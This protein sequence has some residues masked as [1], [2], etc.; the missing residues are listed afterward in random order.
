MKNIIVIFTKQLKDTLKNKAVL[1]QFIL[2]PVMA[3]IMENSI[4]MDAMPMPEHFFVTMFSSMFVGMAPLVSIASIIA[5]EKEQN[6]L[7]ALMMSNVTPIQYLLGIGFYVLFICM[8]SSTAF[9]LCGGYHGMEFVQF[10]LFMALGI[11]ISILIGAIIGSISKNQMAA[12]SLTVPVMMVF[13][14]LP[15]LAMFN[16]TIAKVAKFAY[17]QQIYL[18]IS[19]IGNTTPE[20]KNILILSVNAVISLVLFFVAYIKKGLA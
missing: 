14:F 11:C 18:L 15:M 4:P 8:L 16:D 17:S 12:T 19:N 13:S 20:A 3:V 10:L 6:T 2:F 9:G 5:E 7:R 1:I